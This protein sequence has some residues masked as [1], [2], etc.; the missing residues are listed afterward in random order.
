M[1][2]IFIGSAHPFRGGLATFNERLSR[3]LISMGHEVEIYT[4]TVQYPSFLFPGKTQFSDAAAPDDLKIFRKVNSINPLNWVLIGNEIRRKKP[5][6][7]LYK[8]WL[9]LMGPCFGTIARRAKKNHFTRVISILDNVIPHEKRMGD[10]AFT[11]YFLNACDGFVTMSGSV[12]DDL[13]NLVPGK[14]FSQNPHPLYDNFGEKIPGEEAIRQLNLDPSVHY[15]LFFG[16]IRKYKGLDLLLE[17]FADERLRKF[18]LKLIVAG[19]YYE[20]SKLYLD[21]ISKLNLQNHVILKT[22]FIPEDDVKKYFSA[23]DVIVQPYRSATQSGVTQI[24]YQFNKPMIVTNVGGLPELVPNGKV[25]LCVEPTP[26]AI[27]DA[28]LNFY[29]N[30]LSK[31]FE[32]G[33]QEER[34]RFSWRT[35]AGNLLALMNHP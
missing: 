13:K 14:P 33:I 28:I 12:S 5:G 1:K 31:Q 10:V 32:E 11:K 35:F 27:A 17:A 6:L 3:E 22:D 8:F 19:E 26:K 20:D 2:I 15:L 18:Q 34:K 25:G 23:A 16:F 4:F 9:P 7:L 24:A 21:L 29:A 30:N